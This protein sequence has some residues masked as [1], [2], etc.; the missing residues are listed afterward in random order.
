MSIKRSSGVLGDARDVDLGGFTIRLV[1]KIPPNVRTLL[2]QCY[3]PFM[4]ITIRW[5]GHDLPPE[6]AALPAGE[7]VV[8]PV[9]ETLTD[10]DDRALTEGLAAL[11]RG[12]P[13]APA[14]DVFARL[15][16]TIRSAPR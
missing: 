4:A 10:E 14:K 3:W 9:D 6:L 15:H 16:A 7:N 11:D 12:E 2:A 8:A 13:T 1:R 5:N